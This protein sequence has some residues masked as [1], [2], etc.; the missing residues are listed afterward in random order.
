MYV[1]VMFCVC[2]WGGGASFLLISSFLQLHAV[3]TSLLEG[4]PL[5]H[6]ELSKK[7]RRVLL[8][9]H[10]NRKQ[11]EGTPSVFPPFS[12]S[13]GSLHPSPSPP[14]PSPSSSALLALCACLS[15]CLFLSAAEGLLKVNRGPAFFWLFLCMFALL[16]HLCFQ[17]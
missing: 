1:R 9:E 17:T 10:G 4:I 13:G 11:R 16:S 15:I 5:A 8:C 6:K 14:P 2:V 3:I 12:T 7:G